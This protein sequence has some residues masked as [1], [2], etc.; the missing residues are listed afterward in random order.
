VTT[1]GKDHRYI[2]FHHGSW[3]VV[4]GHRE[5][6][7][8]VKARRSLGTASLRDAQRMRWPIVAELKARTPRDDAEAWRSALK[9][10]AG[11]WG[12]PEAALSDH[13]DRLPPAEAVELA[14]KVYQTGLDAHLDAFLASRGEL[15]ADTQ[16][17]HKLAV[18][19]LAEWLKVNHLP[20]TLQS[21]TRKV[22]TRYV[23][24]LPAG[25]RDPEFLRLQWR[26]LLRRE[27]VDA[28]PWQDLSTAPRRP[29]EPERA[30]TDAEMRWLLEGPCEPAM[31]L[32]MR[33]LALTGARLD[34]VIRME[35]KGDTDGLP[36]F[37]VLPPQKKE[38]GPRTIPLHSHLAGSLA[39]FKGWQWT[40]SG[41]ASLAFTSYRR[42]VL[43]PDPAGRRR[44]VVNAHSFRR[45]FISQAERAGIDERIISDVVGH[46]RRSM[47]G[48]Y[49]AGATMEQ[50]KVCVEA[51]KLP[52]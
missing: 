28:D 17:K 31:G 35:V 22:A 49:S 18:R 1:Q 48:R 23:D 15:K 50:M 26:Y 2:Q 52:T 45:W 32:L 30:W 3:Y 36:A 20:Q 11:G 12:D 38:R 8:V 14:A 21:V 37:I 41:A 44:A 19:R 24:E 9:D 51:V 6:G 27:M 25:R 16:R 43:G 7:R 34:A 29:L 33:V 13:L 42:K 39:G 4:V 40:N 5:G 10:N 47:T 46:A